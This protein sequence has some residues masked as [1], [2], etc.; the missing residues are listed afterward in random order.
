MKSI[1][2]KFLLILNLISVNCTKREKELEPAKEIIPYVEFLK[3]ENTSAKDYIIDLFEKKD[4]VIIC[5]RFHP[6][7]TQYELFLEI[8]KDPRFIKNVGN[9]FIEVCVRNQEEK[10]DFLLRS[11][12]LSNESIDSLVIEIN[13]NSSLHPLWHNYNF[14]YFLKELQNINKDLDNKDKIHLYPSDVAV[15]W[16]IMDS[17]KY[18]AFW[19]LTG[20]R[21]SLMADYIINKFEA[22]QGKNIDRKKALIIMNFRHAFGNDFMYPDNEKPENVGRYLFE[23]YP[24]R[25]A[26]VLLNTLT[27]GS[28]NEDDIIAINDGKWD[29]SFKSLTKDNIGFDLK[30]S[31]FGEDYFDLWPFTEHNFTYSDVFNGFIYFTPIENIKLVTGVP[32]IVD[33]N[34]LPELKRR[35]LLV[36]KARGVNFPLND[37]ILWKYNHKK[38]NDKFINDS[39]KR[40]ID[41]WFE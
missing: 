15:D 36:N 9:I 30:D 31:P 3:K 39:I 8:S 10:I 24:E 16:K 21:D 14:P 25:V 20:Y 33:S 27:F 40:Q 7:F 17:T 18:K 28:E 32:N 37:S 11:E 41:K 38:V 5:E 2:P 34:F 26:N 22:I 12:N 19:K 29:A 6:E 23:K 1:L 13:R 35:N 4:L